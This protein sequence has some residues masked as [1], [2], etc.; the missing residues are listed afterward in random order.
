MYYTIVGLV[1]A[2]RSA[3]RH[4]GLVLVEGVLAGAMHGL[5]HNNNND[6]NNNNNNNTNDINNNSYHNNDNNNDINTSMYII[7]ITDKYSNND[8][9]S[10]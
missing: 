10:L 4:R 3:V 7:M 8:M 9:C 5:L 2:S 6:N 1:V